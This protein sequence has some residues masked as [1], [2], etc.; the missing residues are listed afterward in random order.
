MFEII[1]VVS[2]VIESLAGGVQL[3][4]REAPVRGGAYLGG[5]L[6]N[7]GCRPVKGL[8]SNLVPRCFTYSFL[9]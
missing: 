8:S 6:Y 3:G 1:V 5:F 4:G 9:I 7:G 2:I